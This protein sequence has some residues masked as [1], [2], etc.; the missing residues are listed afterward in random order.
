MPGWA[1]EYLH[2]DHPSN[3]EGTVFRTDHGGEETPWI[4]LRYSPEEG[5]ATSGRF[6]PGS[7]LGTVNVRCTAE[8]PS[9]TRVAVTYALTALSDAGSEVLRSLT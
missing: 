3:D 8:G 5:S 6:T 4:V 1:P 9:V 2:P 7:R